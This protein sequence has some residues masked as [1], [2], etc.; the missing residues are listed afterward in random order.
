MA[1]PDYQ[2]SNDAGKVTVYLLHGIYGAKEYWRPTIGRL[3]EHGYRV[4]AG[5]APG[6][7]QTALPAQMSALGISGGGAMMKL[8]MSHPPLDE[9]IAALRAAR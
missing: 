4:V 7:G 2:L 9:R 1:L 5:E 3:I 8:F 6:Y